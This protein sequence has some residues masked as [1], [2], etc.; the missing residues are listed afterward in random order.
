MLGLRAYASRE[1]I[2]IIFGR[3]RGL[4]ATNTSKLGRQT[5]VGAILNKSKY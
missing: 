1:G 4:R 5:A 2:K 3:A